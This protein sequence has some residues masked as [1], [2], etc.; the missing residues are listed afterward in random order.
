MEKREFISEV[1]F[2]KLHFK[3]H[4]FKV[5]F[6]QHMFNLQELKAEMNVLAILYM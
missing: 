5:V 6:T 1:I 3:N 2:L 4:S